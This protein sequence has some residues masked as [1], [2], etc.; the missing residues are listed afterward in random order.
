[1]ENFD[2]S[3]TGTTEH[4]TPKQD[5]SDVTQRVW[6]DADGHPTNPPTRRNSPSGQRR[7]APSTTGNRPR[8]KKSEQKKKQERIIIICLIVLSAILLVAA[9]L[10]IALFRSSKGND[11][12]ASNVYAAGV[13]LGGMTKEEAIA[14]LKKAT[15]NTYSRID[16]TVQVLDTQV[17]LPPQ[18]THAKLDVEAVVNDAYENGSNKSNN[19]IY[20][21]SVLDYLNLDTAYIRS[22]LSSLGNKYSTTL[23]ET[24]YEIVGARPSMDLPD[25]DTNTVYQTLHIHIGTAEYG[26]NLNA[27]YEQI[28]D[29]YNTNIFHVT[30][31]CTVVAPS[32]LDYDAIY[33]Q[34]CVPPV[35]AEFNSDT[36]EVTPEEYGYGFDLEALKSAV[37]NAPYGSKITVNLQFIEPDITSDFF[38]DKIFQDTLSSYA[39]HISD[40]AAWNANLRLVCQK[41]NGFIIKSGEEFS[42]NDA[43]GKPTVKLGYQSVPVY[44]G[45]G[46]Q[47]VIGG[48]ICQAAST[49]YA[50]ALLADLEITDRT[51]HSY[52]QDFIPVGLDAEVFYGGID[53]RFKNTTDQPIR[54]DASVEGGNL[55]ISLVGNDTKDYT[56]EVNSVTTETLTPGIVY[57]T[58]LSD[59]PGGYLDGDVLSE[60]IEGR[61]VG[62]YLKKYSKSNGR[63]IS[64]TLAAESS[65]A[66]RDTVVVKI[67]VETPDPGPDIGTD[68]GTTPGTE[69]GE[70]IPTPPETG[71]TTESTPATSTPAP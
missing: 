16:M 26:L 63:L 9:V 59:N 6:V 42:F 41:L 23:K 2:E 55:Q 7:S 53:F 46:Y 33:S 28:M 30:G 70:T 35:N 66:K 20:S 49:L 47:D 5:V 4:P 10:M 36:Y 57:N 11:A 52:V 71:E 24:T 60:G 34:F 21:V 1:M 65:Y 3:R 38:T 18:K 51:A 22:V 13:H 56:V 48:G 37:E 64:E 27:L 69:P 40:N 62:V 43:V 29:A 58:M 12:I 31:E 8:Q 15:D 67:Y 50:C 45:R 54:I 39:T 44:I 19:S 14:A 61:T 17:S 68:P 25:K 32:V